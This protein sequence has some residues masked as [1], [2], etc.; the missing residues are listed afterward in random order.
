MEND[1]LK[2]EFS[3]TD[4]DVKSSV[5]MSELNTIMNKIS[6]KKLYKLRIQIK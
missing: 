5:I 2:E 3:H 6:H 4:P 1:N